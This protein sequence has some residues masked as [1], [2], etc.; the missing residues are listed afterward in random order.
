M[1]IGFVPSFRCLVLIYSMAS[2][3][4]LCV[5]VFVAPGKFRWHSGGRG[6]HSEERRA[7]KIGAND[8]IARIDENKIETN[9]SESGRCRCANERNALTKNVV[10]VHSELSATPSFSYWTDIGYQRHIHIVRHRFLPTLQLFTI[11]TYHFP[12]SQHHSFCQ[13]VSSPPTP[14]R[15]LRMDVIFNKSS[16]VSIFFCSSAPFTSCWGGRGGSASFTHTHAHTQTK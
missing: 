6:V 9:A 8:I 5:C 16:C 14:T 7:M 11:C 13:R 12:L 2:N 15:R 3:H 4:I 10:V 1:V